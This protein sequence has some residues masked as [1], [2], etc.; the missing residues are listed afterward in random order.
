MLDQLESRIEFVV[1][2]D[3]DFQ[4]RLRETVTQALTSDPPVDDLNI[5]TDFFAEVSVQ[6]IKDIARV[7]I[8]FCEQIR[9]GGR[10][11][12]IEGH[13]V[14]TVCHAFTQDVLTQSFAE[15]SARFTDDLV[16]F[17]DLCRYSRR[18]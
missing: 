5:T 8:T 12:V 14:G 3:A 2:Y 1:I 15:E 10:P 17:I 4:K 7:R 9:D 11:Q 13:R 18:T 6:V 16:A